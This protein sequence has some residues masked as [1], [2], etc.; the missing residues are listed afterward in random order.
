MGR[1]E[2][3]AM[4]AGEKLDEL[5]AEKI[6]GWKHGDKDRGDMGW[7][8]PKGFARV[9]VDEFSTSISAAWEIVEKFSYTYL[10]RWDNATHYTMPNGMKWECKLSDKGGTFDN[11]AYGITAPEAICKAALI[12]LLEVEK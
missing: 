9:S 3:L 4:S 11:M 10:W 7:Y 12:S 2:I 1:E 8:P 6:M 5:I